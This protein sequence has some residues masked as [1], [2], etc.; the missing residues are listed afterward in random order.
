[1]LERRRRDGSLERP[2]A[3]KYSKHVKAIVQV[4]G[5]RSDSWAES[6]GYLI[7]FVPSQN[8]YGVSEGDEL[9]VL[10]LL[11]GAP[12]PGHLVYASYDGF[13]SGGAEKLE[14]ARVR[15]DDSGKARV[16]ISSTGR[17]YVRTIHM[18]ES[19]EEGVDY[20]SNWATLTF[21]VH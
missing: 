3:E 8:P 9:E 18:V 7:E 10:L 11:D 15:T 21:E 16:P 13:E 4:G 1:V 20:E 5:Q 19:E 6:F 17:W 14:A 2:A 12:V